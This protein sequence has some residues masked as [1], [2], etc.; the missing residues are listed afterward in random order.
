MFLKQKIVLLLFSGCVLL[1]CSASGPKTS[2]LSVLMRKMFNWLK[3]EKVRIETGQKPQAFPSY[4]NKILTSAHTPTKSLA[5]AHVA[6]TDSLLA[7]LKSYHVQTDQA[8]KRAKFNLL[9]SRCIQ[10]HEEECPGPII[11]IQEQQLR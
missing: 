10:C 3:A 6:Y 8:G 1:V 5:P 4:F 7:A 11:Y 9:I 2:E